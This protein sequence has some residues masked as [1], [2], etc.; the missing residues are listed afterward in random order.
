ML[1]EAKFKVKPAFKS[2]VTLSICCLSYEKNKY[3][4]INETTFEHYTS[5]GFDQTTGRRD[6]YLILFRYRVYKS[7]TY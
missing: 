1:I 4:S 2:H 6:N 3:N 7:D 5:F